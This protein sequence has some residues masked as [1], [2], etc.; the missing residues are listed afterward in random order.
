MSFHPPNDPSNPPND[1]SITDRVYKKNKII[2]DQI[3]SDDDDES[4]GNDS[5]DDFVNKYH[6]MINTNTSSSNGNGNDNSIEEEKVL[7]DCP[8]CMCNWHSSGRHRICSLKCGH[9]FGKHCIDKWIA[10][11]GT[12]PQC[13]QKS[14]KRDVRVLFTS[15]FAV[16][17]VSERDKYMKMYDSERSKRKQVQ[18][19][20]KILERK[21][22]IA[23]KKLS[24]SSLPLSNP[25]ETGTTPTTPT[26]LLFHSLFHSPMNCSRALDISSDDSFILVGTS[27]TSSSHGLTKQS[28][29]DPL[30]TSQ[31]KVHSDTVR[32]TT[33][34][35]TN[36]LSGALDGRVV[37]TSLRTEGL[38][39]EMKCS[40][41]VWSCSWRGHYIHVGMQRGNIQIFDDRM[42]TNPLM[43]IKAERP[44]GLHSMQALTDNCIVACSLSHRFTISSD[45]GWSSYQSSEILSSF[46]NS[47]YGG[48]SLLGGKAL[49][50]ERAGNNTNLVLF[51]STVD[52]KLSKSREFISPSP[53]RRISKCSLGIIN[54]TF[55]AAIGDE[56]SQT[57]QLWNMKSGELLQQLQPNTSL[58]LSST[59]S[60]S[61]KLVCMSSSSGLTCH[62][63]NPSVLLK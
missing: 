20:N 13:N 29:F 55:V 8:I 34:Q 45:D 3:I 26:K 17:D 18:T 63:L 60:A 53:Q 56:P 25:C 15:K 16:S 39:T 61:G 50:T 57:C 12:C 49:F 27:F 51:E 10:T 58:V 41:K 42:P 22:Q 47:K 44:L 54:D 35:G 33:I 46:S 19:Q 48:M 43:D 14:R 4:D 40:G 52:D 23:S 21:L 1:Q 36:V 11:K 5:A 9:L 6:G 30:H 7:K 2:N 59:I 62:S 31:L 38:A 24:A 32:T 28:V 37:I